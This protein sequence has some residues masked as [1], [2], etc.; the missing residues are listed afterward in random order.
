M[1]QK[2]NVNGTLNLIMNNVLGRKEYSI[3]EGK[4]D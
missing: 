4:N 3:F 2:G 1:V